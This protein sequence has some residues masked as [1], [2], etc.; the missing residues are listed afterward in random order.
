MSSKL[1]MWGRSRQEY[2]RQHQLR[3]RPRPTLIY[4]D[5][6]N[7][8]AAVFTPAGVFPPPVAIAYITPSSNNPALYSSVTVA[9]T[10]SYYNST[11]SATA[12]LNA[13]G[14]NPADSALALA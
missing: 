11:P 3:F 14:L 5:K 1:A 4:Q 12:T 2:I 8:E 13:S 10:V 7:Y 9:A 6:D